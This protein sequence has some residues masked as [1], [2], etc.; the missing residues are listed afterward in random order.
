MSGI[1]QTPI[2]SPQEWNKLHERLEKLDRDMEEMVELRQYE[3]M[4]DSYKGKCNI[5]ARQIAELRE[6]EER[7]KELEKENEELAQGVQEHF[8]TIRNLKQNERV[9]E[10]FNTKLKAENEKLKKRVEED[11]K[12]VPSFMVFDENK[13]LKAENEKLKKSVEFWQIFQ[14][15]EDANEN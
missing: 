11:H 9:R 5:E 10:A 13:E 3:E 2:Y 14:R 8:Q 15:G 4:V 6:A 7:E 1:Q 12:A